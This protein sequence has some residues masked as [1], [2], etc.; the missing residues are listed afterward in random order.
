M[1][2][3]ATLHQVNYQPAEALLHHMPAVHQDQRR[4]APMRRHHAFHKR[5]QCRTLQWRQRIAGV[6]HF[7]AR[8]VMLALCKRAQ[9]KM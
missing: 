5:V 1:P 2:H 7:T 9:L 8:K 3:D 4:P 6:E